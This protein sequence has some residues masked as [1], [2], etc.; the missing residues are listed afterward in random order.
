[1]TQFTY[2]YDTYCGWCYGASNVIGALIDSGAEVQLMHRHLFQGPNAHR[3]ADGFGQT[4][5]QYDRRIAGLTG[6]EFSQRYADNVLLNAEEILD[7]S[8]T[9]QAAALVHDK[10]AKA[11]FA[12]AK[13]LQKA[14]Y[15]DGKPAV[16]EQPVY[17]ALKAAGVTEELSGGKA[18]AAEISSEAAR[19]LSRVGARGVPAL[20]MHK[21]GQTRVISVADYYD[22]PAAV[23]ALAA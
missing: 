4:A 5:L 12:L 18:R 19:I 23:T 2:I 9:A 16:D 3:M 22:N 10:G 6:M 13:A 11:E 1:M 20:L 17:E 8:K 14:R 15:V 21:D 7:S